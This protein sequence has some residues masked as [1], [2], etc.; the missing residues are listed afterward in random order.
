MAD[1]SVGIACL[2]ADDDATAER[3]ARE[4][5]RLNAERREVEATMQ[6]QALAAIESIAAGNAYTICTYRA[7]WHQGVVGLVASRLKDRF[8]RPSIVFAVAP[9][10][11]C[12]VPGA[13]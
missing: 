10:A 11:N 4:L 13:R 6:E 5:D 9:T 12:G 1:M 7:D 8:H 2:L 3:L